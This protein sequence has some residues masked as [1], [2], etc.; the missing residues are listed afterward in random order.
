M[1]HTWMA[2]LARWSSSHGNM[3]S[4]WMFCFSRNMC[5]TIAKWGSRT[6][7]YMRLSFYHCHPI[8]AS[9]DDYV[10]Q[11][12]KNSIS[13]T[14]GHGDGYG[15][16]GSWNVSKSQQI[17]PTIQTYILCIFSNFPPIGD[18]NFSNSLQPTTLAI[19][20]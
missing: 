12:K 3:C 17:F 15:D 9:K 19:F 10:A 14:W 11:H 8:H 1:Q 7:S 18:D 5:S 2:N 13:W 20:S 6:E 16:Y 4:S